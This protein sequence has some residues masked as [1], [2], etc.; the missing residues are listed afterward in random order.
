MVVPVREIPSGWC[1]VLYWCALHSLLGIFHNSCKRC[2]THCFQRPH[3]EDLEEGKR[4]KN[5]GRSYIYTA[6]DD[7]QRGGERGERITFEGK[8]DDVGKLLDASVKG[9]GDGE[10]LAGD[11]A[12]K[13]SR[14]TPHCLPRL[15]NTMVCLLYTSPS[16]RD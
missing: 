6:D 13:G 1:I 7:E 16:P 4:H 14:K 9:K 3:R 5:P 12:A 11:D 15:V 8:E 10:S 2:R